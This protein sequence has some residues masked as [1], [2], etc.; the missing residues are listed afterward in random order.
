[1]DIN[2]NEL[3]IGA[4]IIIPK[5]NTGAITNSYGFFSI[6]LPPGNYKIQVSSIGFKEQVVEIE[7]NENISQNIYLD[8]DI[9]NLEEVIITKNIEQIDIKKTNNEFKY[10]I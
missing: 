4:N 8:E 10:L 9:E 2:S 3:L 5:I 6:T 7:L 1:M